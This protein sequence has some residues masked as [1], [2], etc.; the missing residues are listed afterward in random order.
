MKKRFVGE[1]LIA[2]YEMLRTT[3]MQHGVFGEGEQW[4]QFSQYGLYGLATTSGMES[5]HVAICCTTP[6]RWCGATDSAERILVDVFKKLI[7]D[8][9]NLYDMELDKDESRLIRTGLN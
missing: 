7:D 4:H 1:R 5:Y 9:S 6:A 2:N 8:S 3:F